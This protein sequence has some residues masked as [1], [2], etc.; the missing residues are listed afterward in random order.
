MAT[1]LVGAFVLSLPMWQFHLFRFLLL[2][3]R[4]SFQLQDENPGFYYFIRDR[5]AE[6][7]LE[8]AGRSGEVSLP[9]RGKGSNIKGEKGV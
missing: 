4:V 1:A 7:A 8:S 6:P 3:F 5:C 9:E 2:S